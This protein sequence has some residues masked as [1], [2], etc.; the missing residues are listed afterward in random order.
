[1]P[2][3]AVKSLEDPDEVIEF[4]GTR[5]RLVDIGDVTVGEIVTQ[6]GW[7]WSTHVRPVVGGDWCQ[8]RHIGIMVSGRIGVRLM[9]GTDLEF[10][11][12]DVFDIPPGHDG[13]TIGDEPAVQI[14][15]A[16]LRAF[17]GFLTGVRSRVL[18]TLL[19][20]DLVD[21]TAIAARLGDRRWR[22]LLSRHYESARAQLEQFGG[23]E[24]DT[25]G[26]GLLA[27]FEGPGLALHCAAAIRRAARRD[28]LAVRAGVHVGEVE[29]V[30]NGI[31]G[32]A[33]HEAARIMSA[34]G[35][36][37]ILVSETT[38]ALAGGSGLRFEDHGM[39]RLRGLDGE[40]RLARLGAE[41]D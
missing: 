36:D 13:W 21:S 40:W 29:L 23:R 39:H 34:A 1:M 35:A 14:E 26:D 9:D 12:H 25:T 20:T 28:G 16:G 32:V 30:G 7:R 4:P 37:E 2:E 11:P 24:V 5:A 18:A 41:G 15:W 33:V 31:R 3:A 17:A 10:K 27:R 22:D 19:F 38:R 8:A 6:P